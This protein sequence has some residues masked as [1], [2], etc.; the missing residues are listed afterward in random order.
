MTKALSIQAHPNKALAEKL[1]REDPLLYRDNNHK[2]EIAL[3][4]TP[5]QALCGFVP[6][7]VHNFRS[8]SLSIILCKH[9]GQFLVQI[10]RNYTRV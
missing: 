10:N 8:F 3:A 2:P 9:L 1:H 6:L 7:K 4:V 5:F